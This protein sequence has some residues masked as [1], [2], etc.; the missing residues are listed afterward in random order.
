MDDRVP[1]PGLSSYL[2]YD[3]PALPIYAVTHLCW[4]ET[5]HRIKVLGKYHPKDYPFINLSEIILFTFG[6]I[7]YYT[8]NDRV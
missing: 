4:T 2:F 5:V 1:T 8:I 6:T 3:Y 7:W